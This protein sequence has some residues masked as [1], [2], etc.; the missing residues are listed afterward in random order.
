MWHHSIARRIQ[1]SFKGSRQLVR[2]ESNIHDPL[3]NTLKPFKRVDRSKCKLVQS[4][5]PCTINNLNRCFNLTWTCKDDQNKSDHNERNTQKVDGHTLFEAFGWSGALVFGW[6]I[7]K[8]LWLER[9]C[10]KSLEENTSLS[11]QGF[12]ELVARIVKTQPPASFVLPQVQV[13]LQKDKP[14]PTDTQDEFVKAANKL[15]IIHEKAMGEALNRRGIACISKSVESEAIK[16]FKRASELKYSPASFNL[17]QCCELGIGTKQD[18]KEAAEWYRLAADQ[19]HA[20]AMYNLGVFYAHGWGGLRADT[21]VAK[22]LFTKAA[23]FGQPDAIAALGK[24]SR[25]RRL[26]EENK[27][28]SS[29]NLPESKSIESQR[30][31]EINIF[32]ENCR[33]GRPIVSEEV[34]H[35]NYQNES[36]WKIPFSGTIA[37]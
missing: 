6:V 2:S 15:K 36:N 34:Y 35:K 10:K 16:F 32:V 17:G 20:T 22:A 29:V 19:G 31:P 21:E 28:T 27:L 23:K 24:E 3:K 8:Q 13:E 26:I 33:N 5:L 9:K 1:Q 25:S 11:P 37:F 30:K 4:F 18:F 7:S 14:E 12:V